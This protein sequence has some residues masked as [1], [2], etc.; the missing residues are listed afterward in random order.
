MADIFIQGKGEF[1]DKKWEKIR[2][3]EL[4]KVYK[5]EEFPAD[6]LLLKS[7][8]PNGICYVD[9][10]NLDGETNL[11]E[12][13]AHKDIQC[14]KDDDVCNLDGDLVCDSP[15]ENLEKWDGNITSS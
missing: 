7:S 13:N 2:M 6:I 14:L 5:D 3:G 10:M 4:L 12:R 9:T 8:K 1:T 15:N 11:K